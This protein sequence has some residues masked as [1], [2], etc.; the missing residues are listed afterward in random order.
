MDG[1]QCGRRAECNVKGGQ[2]QNTAWRED[3]VQYEGKAEYRYEGGQRTVW[4]EGRVQCEGRAEYKESEGR[5]EYR[6]G[7]G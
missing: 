4:R 3:R 6:V 7:G 5:A 1:V 2:N